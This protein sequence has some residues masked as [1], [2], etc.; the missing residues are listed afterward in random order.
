MKCSW[1]WEDWSTQAEAQARAR[2]LRQAGYELIQRRRMIAVVNPDGR[3]PPPEKRSE[4]N[5]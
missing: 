3:I 1:Y 2:Q 5:G 4:S